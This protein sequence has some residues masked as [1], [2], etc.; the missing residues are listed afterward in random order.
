M[1]KTH[2]IFTVLPIKYLVNQYGEPTMTHKLTLGTK[3]SVSN[4]YV[5]FF[6]VLYEKQPHMLTE[7]VKMRYQ[8]QTGFGLSLLELYSTKK[9]NSYTYLVHGNSFSRDVLFDK[10]LYS[11]LAYTSRQYSES[12]VTRP[13]ISY[14]L[15][16][17][18]SHE[19]TGGTITFEQF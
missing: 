5:L 18:S 9:G 13:E 8:S 16:A 14:I 10:I 4:I 2:H 1:F 12:L 6:H 19:Q 11:E 15:Y 3:P 7:D 17:I